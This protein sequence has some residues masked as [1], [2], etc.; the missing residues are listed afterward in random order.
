MQNMMYIVLKLCMLV[1][2]FTIG[3]ELVK[4]LFIYIF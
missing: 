2:I 3:F 4:A 1:V